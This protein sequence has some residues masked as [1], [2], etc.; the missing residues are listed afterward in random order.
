MR[1]SQMG[2]VQGFEG[3]GSQSYNRLPRN[4]S[5]LRSR[6]PRRDDDSP[7][8]HADPQRAS[9]TQFEPPGKNMAAMAGN[10]GSY[11]RIE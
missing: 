11:D 9:Y 3:N 4:T 6:S 7:L 8:Y 2:M 1:D 10:I 5:P